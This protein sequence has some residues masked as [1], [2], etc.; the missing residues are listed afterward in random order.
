MLA[1]F[2]NDKRLLEI[3]LT[4]ASFSWTWNAGAMTVTNIDLRGGDEVGA[5]GDLALSKSGQLSGQLW[6]GT[7][8]K[9]IQSLLGLGDAVFTRKAEG[10]RWARVTVSGTVKDPKQ[11]LSAQLLDQL[12]RHPLAIFGLSGKMLSWYLGNAVGAE[13]E[14][15][16]PK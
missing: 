2:V 11:D 5:Q 1:R 6:V 7:R 16:R 12:H 3:P 9:Y 4:R 8:P 13:D 15:K 10:L 14:W